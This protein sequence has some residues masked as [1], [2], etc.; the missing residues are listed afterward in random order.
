MNANGENLQNTHHRLATGYYIVASFACL[1]NTI[2]VGYM[3]HREYVA[4]RGILGARVFLLPIVM[5]AD[6][7]EPKGLEPHNILVLWLTNPWSPQICYL[8]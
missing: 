3:G 4:W 8:Y 6:F 5:D 2:I 7:A 1:Y